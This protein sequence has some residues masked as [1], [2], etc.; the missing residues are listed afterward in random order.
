M[1][2]QKSGSVSRRL[3]RLEKADQDRAVAELRRAWT[4]LKDREIALIIAPY[5]NGV[6]EPTPEEKEVEEKARV[7]MPEELISRAIGRTEHMESEEVDRRIHVLNRSLGIFER[8]DT[9]RSHMLASGGSE[10]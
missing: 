4:S 3:A 5:A 9:I 7:A 2:D 6:R 8:G 1:A 10:K